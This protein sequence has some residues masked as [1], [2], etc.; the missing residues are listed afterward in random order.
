MKKLYFS[1]LQVVLPVLYCSHGRTTFAPLWHLF[2]L[3][4]VHFELYHDVKIVQVIVIHLEKGVFSMSEKSNYISTETYDSLFEFFSEMPL[5]RMCV[6]ADL[7][8]RARSVYWNESSN[9]LCPDFCPID[10]FVFEYL[11]AVW[12]VLRDALVV[13]LACRAYTK[14]D[15]CHDKHDSQ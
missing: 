8:C 1:G 15:S 12:D 2:F 5:K 6:E 11:D 3:L 14:S 10:S 9:P 4:V 7:L 13:R